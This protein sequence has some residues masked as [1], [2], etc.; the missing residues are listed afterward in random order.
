MLLGAPSAG[1]VIALDESDDQDRATAAIEQFEQRLTD[2][3]W[4]P[5]AD[6]DED[7]LDN[8][9]TD[10][11]FTDCGDDLF[12]GLETALSDPTG[13]GES[14]EFVFIAADQSETNPLVTS[15]EFTTA[16]VV[17]VDTAATD[18]LTDFVDVFA[19]EELIT[20]FQQA[21]ATESEFDDTITS[22][23]GLKLGDQSAEIDFNLNRLVL[24]APVAVDITFDV[25]RQGRAV[26]LL[27]TGQVGAEPMSGLDRTEEMRLLLAAVAEPV[28]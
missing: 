17:L 8:D 3:G 5:D 28:S 16:T 14:D 22:G 21:A 10:D 4:V 27:T 7:D 15:E 2:A 1:A 6:D 26:V 23:P 9:L 12:A 18:E 20:C 25:V 11:A 19:S 24:D 13:F